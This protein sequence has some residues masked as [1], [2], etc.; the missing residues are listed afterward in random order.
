MCSSIA[1]KVPFTKKQQHSH[2]KI[3]IQFKRKKTREKQT[4]FCPLTKTK[5]GKVREKMVKKFDWTFWFNPTFCI[6]GNTL[7]FLSLGRTRTPRILWFRPEQTNKQISSSYTYL[8]YII[9]SRNCIV[10]LAYL[11]HWGFYWEVWR[12][13]DDMLLGLILTRRPNSV[14]SRGP[15]HNLYAR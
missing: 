11:H 8:L 2:I 7:N 12:K 13:C 6:N 1:F 14:H 3:V 5:C 15:I 4:F 9:S 10:K